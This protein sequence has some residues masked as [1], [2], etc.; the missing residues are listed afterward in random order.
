[1]IT[2]GHIP[3]ANCFPVHGPLLLGDVPFD[4]EVVSGEPSLLNR[5]LAT[6]RVQ[7]APC[8]SIEYARHH[9]QYRILPDLAIASAG[10]VRSILLA[11]TREP[12]HLHKCRVGLPTASAS[13]TCLAEILLTKRYGV[14]AE[15]GWF[16]QSSEDPF[17]RFDAALF[18][19]DL[20]L[21]LRQRRED[22]VWTDLGGA[23]TAWTG[24]PFV[25]ALWQVH[26]APELEEDVATC[27]RALL[28][29]KARGLEDLEGLA[30][31][32]PEPFPPGRTELPDY[33]RGLRYD[34]GEDIRQGLVA[35]YTMAVEMGQLEAVPP[36]DFFGEVAAATSS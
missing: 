1:M 13:S 24:L 6:G 27:G 12:E 4:G 9:P 18:I 36:L 10:N 35:F 19:G 17:D 11:G 33:W 16:D 21:D 8:S 26:A 2:L 22:L 20:A 3:Y 14:D 28:E 5:L 23:W 7:V 30:E 31:R 15:F 32:Y 25:Y 34:L 29:S